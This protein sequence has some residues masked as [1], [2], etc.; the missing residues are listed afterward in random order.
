MN[1]FQIGMKRLKVQL[2]RPKDSARPY[3]T[4]TGGFWKATSRLTT[5]LFW[6][7]GWLLHVDER[8]A[9]RRLSADWDWFETFFRINPTLSLKPSWTN[10]FLWSVLLSYYPVSSRNFISNL[11]YINPSAHNKGR[12]RTVNFRFVF[13][14]GKEGP[15]LAYPPPLL[16]VSCFEKRKPFLEKL[17]SR[18]GTIASLPAPVVRNVTSMLKWKFS[19][20]PPPSHPPLNIFTSY[21]AL[22]SS[23]RVLGRKFPLF[24][25]LTREGLEIWIVKEKK[26]LWEDWRGS[27]RKSHICFFGH[28]HFHY[29]GFWIA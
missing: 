13:F 18:L 6:S 16:R 15:W 8:I 19:Y 23:G 24:C 9:V 12:L 28:R 17:I 29:R 5:P 7:W 2:K 4:K 14:L 27:L 21:L 3:W 20:P 25:G 10:F 26:M 22:I 1:G 11:L